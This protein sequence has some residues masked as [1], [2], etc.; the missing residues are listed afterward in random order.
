MLYTQPRGTKAIIVY[1]SFVEYD[2]QYVAFIKKT[3]VQNRS[4]SLREFELTQVWGR[5]KVAVII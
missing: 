1:F 5:P 2:K 3:F 4:L